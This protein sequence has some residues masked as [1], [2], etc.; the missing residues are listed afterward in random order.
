MTRKEFEAIVAEEVDAIPDRFLRE[1]ANVVF[2]VEDE[3]SAEQLEENGV[4]PEETLLG[5]FEGVMLG[6][7][8]SGPWELPGRIIVFRHPTEDEAEE[9]GMSEREIIRDTVWHEVAHYLGMEEH[10]VRG[11]EERRKR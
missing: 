9:S 8:G 2:V 5:L 7:R 3:P 11:A 1:L 4:L 6:E 10:E